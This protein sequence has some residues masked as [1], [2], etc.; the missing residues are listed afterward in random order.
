[1]NIQRTNETRRINDLISLAMPFNVLSGQ[2]NLP[3]V[4][5]NIRNAKSQVEG[6]DPVRS[7]ERLSTIEQQ[8]VNGKPGMP[9]SSS[10]QFAFHQSHPSTNN[11]LQEDKLTIEKAN[12]A[13]A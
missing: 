2:L 6:G 3:P 1:M 13:A 7:T 11:P 8:V 10:H 9:Y 5:G 12:V 4:D